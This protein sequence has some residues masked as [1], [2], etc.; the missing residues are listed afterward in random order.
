M[1]LKLI[2]VI[3]FFHNGSWAKQLS[4]NSNNVL[5]NTFSTHMIGVVK[6]DLFGSDKGFFRLVVVVSIFEFSYPRHQ[7]Y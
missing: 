4:S 3:P 7:H 2:N 1:M 6:F 5:V